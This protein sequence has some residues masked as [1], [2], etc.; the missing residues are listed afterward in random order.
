MNSTSRH[1]QKG[2][3]HPRHHIL[4]P[5]NLLS[6][7]IPQVPAAWPNLK[8]MGGS[9]AIGRNTAWILQGFINFDGHSRAGIEVTLRFRLFIVC[10][11]LARVLHCVAHMF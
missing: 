4:F 1:N 6:L 11:A 2:H 9:Q 5:M 8:G 3:D 10:V 7:L